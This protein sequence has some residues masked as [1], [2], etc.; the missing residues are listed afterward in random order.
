MMDSIGIVIL[1]A[2]LAK[3][4]GKQKLLLPLGKKPI[5]AHI[6]AT[7]VSIPWT[8]SIVVIGDPQNELAEL[9]DQ[10]NIPWIYNS[11][12]H[13]GQASSITLALNNLRTDLE[14]ILF[15]PGDQ[16]LIS[17]ALLQALFDC[18]VST[19]DN[20]SII[21]SQ[22]QGQRYSPVLF[23]SWWIPHLAALSG[24]WGGRVIIREN[25]DYV[26]PVEWSDKYSFYDADTWEDYQFLCSIWNKRDI[27]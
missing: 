25:P 12:R 5:L 26:I 2:G 9:C 20:K 4:M 17:N 15:L 18:F 1:A 27:E 13:T 16:P 3:R 14:G 6:I 7:A 10:Y 19:G 24:D 23:G 8:D 22:Y 21:V 11:Q